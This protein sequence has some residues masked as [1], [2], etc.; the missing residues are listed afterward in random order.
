M[1]IR[2]AT[3]KDIEEIRKISNQKALRSTGENR[4]PSERWL[5]A[6]IKE[7]QIFFVADKNK[8]VYGFILGEQVTGDLG[9]LWL[10]GVKKEFRSKGIG[11]LLL[12]EFIH[13]CK[14]RKLR[15]IIT[16]GTYN[17]KTLNFYKKNNFFGGEKCLEL[18]LRLIK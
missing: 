14:K 1:K 3:I 16:Y 2:K 8:E 6:F 13:E 10:I 11:K 12:N 18:K 15:S 5:T 4:A 17:K 9:Y 7:K